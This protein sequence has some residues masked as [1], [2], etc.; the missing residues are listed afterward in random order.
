M[1]ITLCINDLPRWKT[2]SQTG[3]YV[4][5]TREVI[6][7]LYQQA[8]R[9]GERATYQPTAQQIFPTAFGA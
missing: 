9:C 1:C 2:C 7:I 6:H 8:C 3:V 4:W 5:S